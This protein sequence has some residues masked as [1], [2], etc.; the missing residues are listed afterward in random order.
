MLDL[1]QKRGPISIDRGAASPTDILSF[2]CRLF[3]GELHS[4]KEK[5]LD[6]VSLRTY[7]KNM[8]T[9]DNRLVPIGAFGYSQR[10][11]PAVDESLKFDGRGR[12]LDAGC[13]Y[14]TESLLFSLAGD[15]VLG[16]DLVPERIEIAQSRI[17]YYQSQCDF[18]LRLKFFAANIF[19]FLETAGP[20]DIIWLMEA[21]SHIYPA[22][23]FLDLA[24]SSLNKGGKLIIT[25]PN[26]INPVAWLRSIKIRGALIHKPHMNF[27]DPESGVPV[28]YGQE[29]IY[30]V[31]G[32]EKI[33][34]R[35]GFKIKKTHMSGFMGTSLFPQSWLD[36]KPVYRLMSF[37]HNVL[38]NLPL[39]SLAGSTFT[40]VAVKEE[41]E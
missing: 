17:P 37:S 15:E 26:R 5:G 41:Q 29:R 4:R 24:F 18:P 14:G 32:L 20:F 9:R 10:L 38:R 34:R 39:I 7:Y 1:P 30:S 23:E 19:R 3:E 13:G 27:K 25:D 2:F 6:F 21:I 11:I 33:L 35:T 36:K 28:E 31:F 8:F 40:I 12:I 22:D 16:V